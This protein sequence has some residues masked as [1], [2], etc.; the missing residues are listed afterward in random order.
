MFINDNGFRPKLIKPSKQAGAM[1]PSIL[2]FRL[3]NL[4]LTIN[5]LPYNW[6]NYSANL[7]KILFFHTDLKDLKDCY[8]AKRLRI[9]ASPRS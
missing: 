5:T 3:T 1:P 8:A 7:L 2:F 6:S 4:H 9:K